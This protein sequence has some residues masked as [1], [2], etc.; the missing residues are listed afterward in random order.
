MDDELVDLLERLYREV[1]GIRRDLRPGDRLRED[2]GLDSLAIAE[3][4]TV[5]EEELGRSLVEDE[6]IAEVETVA[7][8]L[9]VIKH[10]QPS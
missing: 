9:D 2:L 4:L 3:L 10:P 1:R 8:V 6:R 5:L 7:D